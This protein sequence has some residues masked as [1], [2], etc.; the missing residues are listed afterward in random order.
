M[1]IVLRD[2]YNEK[3]DILIC[4]NVNEVYGRKIMTLLNKDRTHKIYPSY[5]QMVTDDYIL[6]EGK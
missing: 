1:K 6:K 3:A 4:E 5:Y 2:M